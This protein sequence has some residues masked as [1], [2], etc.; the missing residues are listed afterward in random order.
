MTHPFSCFSLYFPSVFYFDFRIVSEECVFD[1]V[2]S[3]SLNFTWC[4]LK[5]NILHCVTYRIRK[6]RATCLVVGTGVFQI[7]IT[8]DLSSRVRDTG[9]L[10]SDDHTSHVRIVKM[11]Y[12]SAL[13]FLLFFLS[14]CARTSTRFASTICE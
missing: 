3:M 9:N 10:F 5:K 4:V 7:V 13:L 14:E 6:Y 12:E 11:P 2:F 1:L 8:C